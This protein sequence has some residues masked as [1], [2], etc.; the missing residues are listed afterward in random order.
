MPVAQPSSAET[1]NDLRK[2]LN[3]AFIKSGIEALND[4]NA[5]LALSFFER[6]HAMYR[7][8]ISCSFLAYCMAKTGEETNKA[9]LLC[10]D[11]IREEADNPV[12]YLNLGRIYLLEGN[13]KDAI[14]AFQDG[15]TLG[16]NPEIRDE[17]DKLGSRKKPLMPL[18]ERKNPINKYLGI[19]LKKLGLR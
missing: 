14:K 7:N 13:K 5:I 16:E 6:A 15:L 19:V 9:L 12:H 18:L 10:R 11:A 2:E 8:P 17:L 4:D 1:G 3:A